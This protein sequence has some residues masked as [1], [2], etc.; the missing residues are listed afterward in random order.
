[1]KPSR[2]EMKT[3]LM[4]QAEIA[5]DELLDFGEQATEPTLTEIEEAVLKLRAEMGKQAALMLIEVQ[6]NTH[7]VP[8]PRCPTCGQEMHYKGGKGEIVE[9]RVGPLP[10]KRG[11]YYC[12]SCRRGLFPPG[13]PV[14]DLGQPLER[15]GGETGGVAEWDGGV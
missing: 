4:R 8:G 13:S 7:P 2:S 12:E 6:P 11:Y 1:M 15:A 5:I 14:A 9:S 3:A 10:L